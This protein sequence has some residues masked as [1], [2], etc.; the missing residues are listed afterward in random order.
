MK[1]VETYNVSMH[2]TPDCK[3]YIGVTKDSRGDRWE[4]ES[5]YRS[6]GKFTEAI[7]EWEWDG[8]SHSIVESGLPRKAAMNMRAELIRAAGGQSLNTR[9]NRNADPLERDIVENIRIPIKK[10]NNMKRAK[11]QTRKNNTISSVK[12]ELMIDTRYR[13]NDGRYAVV[14]RVYSNA[15]YVYLQTGYTMTPE[16]FMGMDS[17]TE[18]AIDTKYAIVKDYINNMTDKGRFDINAIKSETE[19]RL[20][21]RVSEYRTLT[22]IITEKMGM[23]T[24]LHSIAN[25]RTVIKRMLEVFHDGLP[26]NRVSPSTIGVFMNRLKSDG[27]SDTTLN[28]YGTIIK[29]C[30]N[31]GIYKGVIG[32]DQYPFKRHAVEIDKVSLPKCAKRDMEYLTKDE[33]RK[34]WDWFIEHKDRNI[35]YFLF[36][37]LHGG[38]NLADLMTLKFDDLYFQ[39]GGF[40]YQ[41]RKTLTKN[42]FSVT[43][44]ATKW[45]SQLFD[46]M[47]IVPKR[48]EYVFPEMAHDGTEVNYRLLKSRYSTSINRAVIKVSKALGLRESS[49][50]TARHTFCTVATKERMPYSMIE[51]AMGHANNG[52][53]GHYIGGFTLAEMRPDFE[54]LL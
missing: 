54:R 5:T 17:E 13:K 47:G 49:M 28:I 34:V 11:K 22:G 21:G 52:V 20:S 3:V 31:Y 35:G 27:L 51:R 7:C 33:I 14:I 6:N 43:V 15:K 32:S 8:I 16:E 12:M 1:N 38:M 44:P 39:E 25:Y 50:T 29:S 23:M 48:G 53:S 40:V 2:I 42:N 41:R 10:P 46:T 19:K 37:Y 45:T 36:A 9:G 30:I 24:N 18:R 26:L 4:K